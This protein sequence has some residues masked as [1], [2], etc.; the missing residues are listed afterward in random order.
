MT[1]QRLTAQQACDLGVVAEVLPPDKL[2]ARAWE[3]AADLER[4]PPAA[5]RNTRAALTHHIKKRLLEELDHGLV[6]E[7]VAALASPPG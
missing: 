6:L 1:G 2:L 3:L 5:L 4:K 7:A